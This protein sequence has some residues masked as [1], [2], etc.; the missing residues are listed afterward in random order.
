MNSV[1]AWIAIAISVVSA[2]ISLAAYWTNR[3]R[4]RL[5]LYDRRFEIYGRAHDLYSLVLKWVP[6][7]YEMEHG[8]LSQSPDL[9]AMLKAF[10]KSSTEGQFLFSAESDV[11][12]LLQ[13]FRDGRISHYQFQGLPWTTDCQTRP[14]IVCRSLQGSQPAIDPIH[15]INGAAPGV[16]TIMA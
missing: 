1:I 8:T 10:A 4:F 2:S 9:D 11:P 3:E 15:G 16:K 6:T 5:E 12:E 7:A 13:V 14:H